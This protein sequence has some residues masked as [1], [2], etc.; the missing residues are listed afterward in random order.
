MGDQF[1]DKLVSRLGYRGPWDLF[2]MLCGVIDHR[3]TEDDV[4]ST[5]DLGVGVVKVDVSSISTSSSG[6]SDHHSGSICN[7]HETMKDDASISVGP[8]HAHSHTA[9]TLLK[10]PKRGCWRILD[11]GCG[12]G[13]VGK[14]FQE[15]VSHS[16]TATE[17][18]SAQRDTSRNTEGSDGLGVDKNVGVFVAVEGGSAVEEEGKKDKGGEDDDDQLQLERLRT[19][20]AGVSKRH[21]GGDKD[22]GAGCMIGV[23]VSMRMVEITR[24]SGCYDSV[25][26]A[27]LSSALSLFERTQ[28]PSS[29]SSSSSS[30]GDVDIDGHN[31]DSAAHLDTGY[32]SGAGLPSLDLI[33]AADTFIYVGALGGVFGQVRKAL[34]VNGIFLFSIEDLDSSPMRVAPHTHTA[35]EE[36]SAIGIDVQ[37]DNGIKVQPDTATVSN[38]IEVSEKCIKRGGEVVQIEEGEPVGA[39]PGW[40]GQLLKSARFAHSNSYIQILCEIHGFDVLKQRSIVLRTEETIPLHGILYVLQVKE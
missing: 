26:R 12:S 18:H 15:L 10:Y 21:E 17:K 33:I 27:D 8:T 29:S 2:E 16:G 9:V 38:R 3:G 31:Q 4:T 24:R 28:T 37:A 7:G 5:S 34:G 30:G 19:S 20:C 40:G 13:L 39:V 36:T 25:G 35:V 32:S 6:S 22:Q 1:E 23:D 14:V 11:L